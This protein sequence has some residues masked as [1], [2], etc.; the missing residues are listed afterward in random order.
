MIIQLFR[1]VPMA[2]PGEMMI[3]ATCRTIERRQTGVGIVLPTGA[4]RRGFTLLELLLAITLMG[5]ML[6]LA[7]P[8]VGG[9]R[10]AYSATESAK[11]LANSI[12]AARITAVKTRTTVALMA[13]PGRRD[14]LE[15]RRFSVRPWGGQDP[16]G[17]T[18]QFEESGVVW[19]APVARD[20]Q[21]AGEL[22]LVSPGS[23]ILFFPNGTSSGGEI[24]IRDENG[25]LQTHF[26]VDALT[27]ELFTQ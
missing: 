26:L 4:N 15:E 3:S 1:T 8:R 18:F 6:G 13:V 23:G 24:L 5:L 10:T 2:L 21:L 14:L 17:L 7:L 20:H 27:G 25:K 19:D 11:S 22:E 9:V 16:A 12:R